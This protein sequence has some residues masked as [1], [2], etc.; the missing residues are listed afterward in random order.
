[1]PLPVARQ[2]AAGTGAQVSGIVGCFVLGTVVVVVDEVDEGLG[3]FA[4]GIAGAARS[5]WP[6]HGQVLGATSTRSA[7]EASA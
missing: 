1:L 7:S 2:S 3:S 6:V 4:A 5:G